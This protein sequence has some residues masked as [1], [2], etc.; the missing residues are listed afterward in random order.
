MTDS[1]QQKCREWLNAHI[2]NE[3]QYLKL[4]LSSQGKKSPREDFL[5]KLPQRLF[6][7]YRRQAFR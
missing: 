1:G 4:R 7:L 5:K 3:F 2:E 6:V